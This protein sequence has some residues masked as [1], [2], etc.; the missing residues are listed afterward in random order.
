[1]LGK[2]EGKGAKGS[3]EWDGYIASSAQWTWVCTNSGDRGGQKACCATIHEVAKSLTWL[4]DWITKSDLSRQKTESITNLK[5]FSS[6]SVPSHPLP[7]L[8]FA[9]VQM[10]LI[11]LRSESDIQSVLFTPC[12][13]FSTPTR[14]NLFKSNLLL[15]LF[16]ETSRAP[17]VYRLNFIFLIFSV[18]GLF[19]SGSS[20]PHQSIE[21]EI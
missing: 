14:M 21:L 20:L 5:V 15:A 16:L 12:F 6:N 10:F 4:S 9:L 7:P 13:A 3:R 17:C 19:H 1:M 11:C 18:Y 8:S 2:I